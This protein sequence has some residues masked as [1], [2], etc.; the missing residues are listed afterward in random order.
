MTHQVAH[1]E[2]EVGSYGRRMGHMD[3]GWGI[4]REDGPYGQR[5]GNKLGG[6]GYKMGHTDGR[7]GICIEH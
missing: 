5:V 4:R 2:V 7:W 3:R 1:G 6:Q